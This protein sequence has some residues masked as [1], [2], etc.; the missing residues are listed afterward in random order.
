MKKT[1]LIAAMMFAALLSRAQW[2][3]DV[4]LTNNSFSSWMSYNNARNIAASGDSV[5]VVW[6]D[7]RNG[8]SNYEIYYKRSTDGGIS[9]GTDKRLTVSMAYSG[10][11]SLAAS[12]TEV[13]VIL[14]ELRFA[15]N[16]AWIN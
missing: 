7:N 1:V 8:A 12:G 10:I 5:H 16:H 11:P 13:H 9:W 3:P 4:R 6:Y 14:K 2:E 15:K